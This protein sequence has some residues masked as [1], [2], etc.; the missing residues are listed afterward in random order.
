M[1]TRSILL[2]AVIFVS[3]LAIALVSYWAYVNQFQYRS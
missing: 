2:N 1:K 3:L